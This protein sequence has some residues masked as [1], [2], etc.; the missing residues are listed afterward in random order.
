MTRFER[1]LS[2]AGVFAAVAFSGASAQTKSPAEAF[3]AGK[4]IDLIVGSRP[5]GGYATY[6]T[7][8]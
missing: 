2:L 6:A 1:R 8:L 3:F 5:G 7:L 4:S